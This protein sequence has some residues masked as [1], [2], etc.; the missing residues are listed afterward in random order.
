[1]RRPTT[2]KT[3]PTPQRR[4]AHGS[5]I[6][7]LCSLLA[8]L[9]LLS[10]SGAAW[11]HGR[12][13]SYSTWEVDEA[14]ARVSLRLQLLELSRLGPEA[15]PP[16][17]VSSQTSAGRPDLPGRAF[18]HELQ[19]VADGTPCL[20]TGPAARRPDQPGWVRY[21]WR[22][23][24]PENAS[25]LVLRS[26]ILLA[27]SPSHLHFARARFAKSSKGLREQVLTEAAPEFVLRAAGSEEQP[28]EVGGSQF[29]DYLILGVEHILSGWDHLAFLLGLLLL[30]DRLGSVAR[31]VTG[32]TLAHSLTLA[33]AVLGWVHPREAAVEAVIAFSV[34]L[35]AVEKSWRL[36]GRSRLLPWS[37]L[38]ALLALA[39]A[40]STGLTSLPLLTAL[41]LSFFTLCYFALLDRHDRDWW[42]VCLTFAF[43]LVH[44]F[45]F[46]GILVEMSL[47]PDRLVPALLGFNLGV[48]AGQ[49]GVVLLLWPV[50]LAGRRWVPSGAGRLGSEVTAAA[51]CGLGVYWLVT[52]SFF[53]V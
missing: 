3:P 38:A 1:M 39:L 32:F 13:A 52:R 11:S 31:L 53:D 36:S 8:G 42:R 43:G 15:L 20:P 7:R 33:L 27:V 22:V 9:A 21:E 41:G 37:V 4:A 49:L 51:L 10:S 50:L 12:S 17:T 23:D 18:P 24:C 45:G 47:P 28:N 5:K 48:E 14:G 16:G 40:S 29:S 30:A 44:G 34:A 6:R 19:L 25:R 35:V 46:A 26:R 2:W